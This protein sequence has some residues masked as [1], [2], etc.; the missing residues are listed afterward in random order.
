M[1]AAASIP[2]VRKATP[3]DAETILSLVDALAEYEKLA[4]PDAE[5]KGRLIRDMF[6]E[7]P[8]LNAYLAELDG[9]PAGYAFVFET[10][11]SF[12]ALPTLYLEDLFVLPEYRG[13]KAGYA[14]FAEMVKEAYT[15]GCGRMEWTVLDWNQ[16]AIDFYR[17]LGAS[18]MRDWHL[19][20]LV[21]SDMK[22][23]LDRNS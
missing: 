11:S 8:K 16:L 1:N 15:R 5:A 23:L 12:L 4:P 19:Y 3:A 13:K 14:L 9:K 20:R 10:Y 17:R 18:H 21:R 2:T 22:E 7:P 6:S